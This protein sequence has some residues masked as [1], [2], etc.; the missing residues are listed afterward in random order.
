MITDDFDKNRVLEWVKLALE[1]ADYRTP[2][3]NETNE[4]LGYLVDYCQDV[5]VPLHKVVIILLSEAI[6]DFDSASSLINSI[7]KSR[8]RFCIDKI[9]AEMRLNETEE[10]LISAYEVIDELTNKLD[11]IKDLLG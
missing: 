1:F 3:V 4:V 10:E 9:S 7:A 6:K 11:K 8:T 2:S 5:D